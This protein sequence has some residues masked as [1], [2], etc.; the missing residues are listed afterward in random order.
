MFAAWSAKAR[1]A[2]TIQ[3]SVRCLAVLDF[4]AL[5]AGWQIQ[6]FSRPA[7]AASS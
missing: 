6:T 2:S 4:S 7:S 3:N 5:N 1:S